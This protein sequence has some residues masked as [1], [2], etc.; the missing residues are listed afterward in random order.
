MIE[1]VT[2]N[3]KI[4]AVIIYADHS[5]NGIKFITPQDFSMQMAFMKHEQGH[6]ITAHAHN[7]FKREIHG[8]QEVLIIRK[9]KVKVNFYDDSRKCVGN[10]IISSGD[11]ILLASGG[12]GFEMLEDT[13]MIEIKQGPYCEGKDKEKF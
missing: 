6:N 10:K 8:T 9:G 13:E 4:L 12:H 11:V 7:M 3:G 1:E 5:E 2:N